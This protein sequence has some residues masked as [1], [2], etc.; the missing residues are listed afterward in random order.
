MIKKKNKKLFKK[1]CKRL[2]IKC[3][4]IIFK[5]KASHIGSIY[6]CLDI[7]IYIYLNIIK[8]KK[9]IPNHDFI[10]SKGHAGLAVYLV[11]YYKK[12]ISSKKISGYYQNGS[13][14][15][16]HVSHYRNPGIE[17]SS[18]SLG[19]GLSIGCGYAFGNMINGVNKKTIVMMSDGECNEGSV[20]EAVLFASHSK[21]KN[22]ICIIDFNN[23]QS[24][25][26]IANTLDTLP[27]DKKFKSFGWNVIEING[28]SYED[29][30]N[31]FLRKFENLKP[32]CV[33]AKTVKGKGVSFMENN[34]LW[35]Y[36]SPNFDELKLAYSE[37]SCCN[38]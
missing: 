18:G 3:L 7:I 11:L 23:L 21:L 13:Y 32:L 19:H 28:H 8:F 17:I 14:L 2:R 31:V 27:L 15:S 36:R 9:K 20:W 38:N 12:I 1:V 26:T 30:E 16:G 34:V 25:D 37:L 24:L 6:S 5:S 10:M 4:E 22:L 33:I 35:H 29:L